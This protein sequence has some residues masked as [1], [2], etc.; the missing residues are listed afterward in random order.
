M[1][2]K[3]ITFRC[4]AIQHARINTFL[5]PETDTRTAFIT[6]A[7]ENFLDF[8]GQERIRQLNLFELVAEVDAMFPGTG[9]AEQA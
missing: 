2:L 6:E 5:N 3:S 9:F 8:A 1:N 4:S 7:L